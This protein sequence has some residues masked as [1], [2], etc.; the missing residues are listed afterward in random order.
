PAPSRDVRDAVQQFRFGGGTRDDAMM[1]SAAA[2][3]QAAAEIGSFQVAFKIAGR[4]SIGAADGAKSLRISTANIAPDLLV[5]SV[6]VID[7]TAFLEASF[8]QTE[9]ATLLPGKVAIYRDG[10]FV[11][12]GQM[13]AASKDETVRLGFG[14][15][16]KIKIERTVLKR[17]E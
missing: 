12:R 2:E 16:D 11:G 5:R 1:M 9:D 7:P 14:A 6:P 13:A 10:A 15:D 17:N 4:V 3:Q 8:K